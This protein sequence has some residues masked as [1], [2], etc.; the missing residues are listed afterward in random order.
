MIRNCVIFFLFTLLGCAVS[1]QRRLNRVWPGYQHFGERLVNRFAHL[2]VSATPVMKGY[3]C[4]MNKD[5]LR[6]YIKMQT[7]YYSGASP[8]L[9]LPFDKTG[10][11]DILGIRPAE[12]DYVSLKKAEG[13]DSAEYMYLD[14]TVWQI[15]GRSGDIRICYQARD[16]NPSRRRD[17]YSEQMILLKGKNLVNIAIFQE[18]V[19]HKRPYYLLAFI[20]KEY[21][22]HFSGSDLKDQQTMIHYILDKEKDNY[23]KP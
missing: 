6:G 7:V 20:N 16:N 11:K 10:E 18:D 14:S 13:T 21:G 1:E 15:L 8:I 22:K 17:G 12:V 5:T 3:V 2:S 19:W 9:L 23:G 4:K